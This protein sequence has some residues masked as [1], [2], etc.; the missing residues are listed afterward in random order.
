MHPCTAY[1]QTGQDE[2]GYVMRQPGKKAS[3][4]MTLTNTG[5][6]DNFRLS[7]D[8]D[9]S[10]DEVNFFDYSMIPSVIYMKQNMTTE[11]SV[12]ITLH[13]NAPVGLSITFT[14]VVQSVSDINQGDYVTFDVTCIRSKE[15]VSGTMLI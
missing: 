9:A 10:A 12:E 8:T 7:V 4:S 14:V 6:N 1:L 15:E 2:I 3:V 11:V 5:R 13:S